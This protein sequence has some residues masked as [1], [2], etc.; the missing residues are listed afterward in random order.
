MALSSSYIGYIEGS[1]ENGE[2]ILTDVL[3][4]VKTL[5]DIN[6]KLSSGQEMVDVQIRSQTDTGGSFLQLGMIGKKIDACDSW[7]V[8]SVAKFVE[9]SVGFICVALVARWVYVKMMR[10]INVK[11][12]E[13]HVID[14]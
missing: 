5:S 12:K 4:T 2:P 13:D 10:K 1:G 3:K 6:K 11:S 7:S 14:V 9:T 8:S